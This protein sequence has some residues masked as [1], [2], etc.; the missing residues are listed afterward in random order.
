MR[1]N[2]KMKTVSDKYPIRVL[3]VVSTL[4]RG[5]AE[6]MVMNLFRQID[7]TKVV[8]DFVKHTYEEGEF[9]EEIRSL[10]GQI[11]AAPRY[12]LYNHLSY[13]KWWSDFLKI[14]P[15]YRIIH[16]HFFTISAVFFRTAQKYGRITV[17]HCHCTKAPDSAVTN[18][19]KNRLGDRL[20]MAAERYSDYCLA[21]SEDA[22]KWMFR[23]KHFTVLHN[24]I[25]PQ[26][27]RYDHE[28]ADA[29]RREL[30]LG[31]ALVL[32]TVG[33]FN[34]QKNPLGIV[35]IFRLVHE[36]K[37]NARLLWVGTG[38]MQQEAAAKLREYGIEND[39]L[40]LGVRDDVPRLLQ[41]MDVFIFPSFY[42]GLGVALIEAQAAGLPCFASDTI[43]EEAKVTDLVHFLPL[44]SPELWADAILSD[45][46]PRRKTTQQIIDAG[47]DIHTTAKWLTDFYVHILE[48][49]GKA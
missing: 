6:S 11:Y 3:C 44:N 16:G 42:E 25:D 35:E 5:G 21:C 34:L 26:V 33:R 7:R 4:G 27:F 18:G 39:V 45:H 23:K 41:A 20:I 30:G 17:A 46:T 10:G 37:P 1:R 19:I 24:A 22:G 36:A 28:T 48:E 31:S 40:F 2:Q 29:V 15:E 9:E 38:P 32:G 13:T 12:K 49:K 47:Y 14:H 8:F 43:P